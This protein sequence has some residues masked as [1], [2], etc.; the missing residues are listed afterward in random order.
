[1]NAR[2][3]TFGTPEETGMTTVHCTSTKVRKRLDCTKN[4]NYINGSVG[5]D[6]SGERCLL[7]IDLFPFLGDGGQ[8]A[9]RPGLGAIAPEGFLIY[10]V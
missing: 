6:N 5:V 4:R 3:K 9:R 2:A 8:P 10:R 1:V 7:A